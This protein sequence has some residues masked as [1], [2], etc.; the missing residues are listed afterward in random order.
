MAWMVA[1]VCKIFLNVAEFA[2]VFVFVNIFLGFSCAS[3]RG[4]SILNLTLFIPTY[5]ALLY[6]I[7][8]VLIPSGFLRDFF[9]SFLLQLQ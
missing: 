1:K 3:L 6:V 7:I 4:T 9:F 5:V 2:N 8:F